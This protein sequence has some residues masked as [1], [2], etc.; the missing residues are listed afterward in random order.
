MKRN[1]GF[2]MIEAIVIVG[3]LAVLA[4]ILTPLVIQEVGKSKVSRA[5]SDMEAISTAF[6][7]YYMDTTFWPSKWTGSSND[8]QDLVAF[9]CLYSNTEGL[10]TWDGPYMERGVQSGSDMV[11]ALASNGVYRGV[12]DPWGLPYKVYYGKK[13]TNRGGPGGAIAIISGGPDGVID[14]AAQRLLQG[15][16]KKDDIIAVVTRKVN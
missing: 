2:T 12:V 1:A 14:T 4:G 5:K 16:P 11:V 9:S 8:E 6:N 10:N 15:D 7:Q 13:G 3:I